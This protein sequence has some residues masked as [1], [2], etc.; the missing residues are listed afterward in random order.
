MSRSENI[1]PPIDEKFKPLTT[2]KRGHFTTHLPR[3]FAEIN[4]KL[5]AAAAKGKQP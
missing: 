2:I 1:E 4:A 3:K 5:A